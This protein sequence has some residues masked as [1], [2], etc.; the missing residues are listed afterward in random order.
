MFHDAGC[1]GWTD[2]SRRIADAGADAVELN[3]Y[4][5]ATDP[6]A[7]GQ[8]VEAQYLDVVAAIRKQIDIPLAVKIGPFFSALPYFARQLVDAGGPHIFVRDA[9]PSLDD[10]AAMVGL[11]HVDCEQPYLDGAAAAGIRTPQ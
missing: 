5:V 7:S 9:D 4:F 6:A 10:D 8:Q 3:L 11:L 1:G 2:Y